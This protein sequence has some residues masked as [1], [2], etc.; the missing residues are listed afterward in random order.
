MLRITNRKIVII[1]E[2]EFIKLFTYKTFSVDFHA[3]IIDL[4][5]KLLFFF[6]INNTLAFI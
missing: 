6:V 3:T 1:V 2:H 4:I 5:I